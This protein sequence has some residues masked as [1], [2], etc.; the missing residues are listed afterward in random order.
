M[1][2]SLNLQKTVDEQNKLRSN[3]P[4]GPL[5]FETL[6]KAFPAKTLYVVRKLKVS[7]SGDAV[8]HPGSQTVSPPS[9]YFPLYFHIPFGTINL[10]FFFYGGA[11]ITAVSIYKKRE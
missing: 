1:G 11:G 6:L 8:R 9:S 10:Y 3:H 7:I 5:S 4:P 2:G